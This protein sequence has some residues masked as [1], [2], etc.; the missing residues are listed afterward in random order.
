MTWE[1]LIWNKSGVYSGVNYIADDAMMCLGVYGGYD[2]L[3]YGNI[4]E[5]SFW[6]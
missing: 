3:V 5:F 4:D 2:D 1:V 6:N